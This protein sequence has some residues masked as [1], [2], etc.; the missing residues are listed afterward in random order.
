M[1]DFFN[2]IFNYTFLQNALL[3]ALLS[4]ISCGIMGSYMVVK[5]MVFLGGGITHSSFGGV[6]IAYYFG[7]SP[8]LGALVGALMSAFAIESISRKSLRE[9]T[10]IGI[11]WSVGMAV[12]VLFVMLTPGYAPN[13]M[14]FLFG[15]ILMVSG[16]DLVLLAVLDFL[17]VAVLLL[18]YRYIVYIAMDSEFSRSMGMPV[19]LVGY[20]VMV[21]LSLAIVLNIKTVGIMLLMSLLTI[22]TAIAGCF[23]RRFAPLIAISVVVALVG[24]V[25]GIMLSYHYNL[26]AGAISVVL[27]GVSYFVIRGATMLLK[28]RNKA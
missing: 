28:L 3:A 6:G 21:F 23:V 10:A 9:D 14:S 24:L 18:F 1:I 16:L 20:C 4:A 2:D 22:P 12:G 25:L 26:P 5:R 15:N 8:T 13:L 11:L 19:R 27:L 7:V 17:L